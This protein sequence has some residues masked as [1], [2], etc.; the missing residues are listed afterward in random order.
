MP[1]PAYIMLGATAGQLRKY[2]L[3]TASPSHFARRPQNPYFVPI[4]LTPAEYDNQQVASIV[5]FPDLAGGFGKYFANT[6]EEANR[7]WLVKSAETRFPGTIC[8]PAL[9]T[10]TAVPT[11]PNNFNGCAPFIYSDISGTGE[12]Y[13]RAGDKIYTTS[14]TTWADEE[15]C[16]N[17]EFALRFRE[18]VIGTSRALFSLGMDGTTPANLS[19]TDG[20]TWNTRAADVV[21]LWQDPLTNTLMVTLSATGVVSTVGNIDLV[22]GATGVG[23]IGPM[24]RFIGQLEQVLYAIDR[25]GTLWAIDL[26]QASGEIVRRL[27]EA[28][29]GVVDGCLYQ[30]GQ[31]AL[32][33]GKRVILWHPARASRDVTPGA[34]DGVPAAMAY[35]IRS[36]VSINERLLAVVDYASTMGLWELR[37]SAWHVVT[38]KPTQPWHGA[39][40]GVTRRLMGGSGI[41][42]DP[43]NN[44]IWLASEASSTVK[45]WYNTLPPGGENVM[46]QE[47]ITAGDGFEATGEFETP[48]HHFGLRGLSGPLLRLRSIGENLSVARTAVYKYRV[49]GDEASAWTSIGTAT[50][51][52]QEFTFGSVGEGAEFS[53]VRF[54]VELARGASAT[55][56]DGSFVVEFIKIP[57]LQRSDALIIDIEATAT[58]QRRSAMAV[59]AALETLAEQKT[60]VAYRVDGEQSVSYRKLDGPRYTGFLMDGQ[61]QGSLQVNANELT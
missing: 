7:G 27:P 14:T 47:L 29:Y 39:T 35:T 42:Y 58:A 57:P 30:S 44:R 23:N 49:N 53:E 16:T 12:L 6:R 4:R 60:L 41:G 13:L 28:L 31:L 51:A 32:T 40:S 18:A 11:Q 45:T 48:W 50:A 56:P 59:L 46:V 1:G 19:S 55:S 10:E 9:Y 43:E 5:A 24:P 21:D 22:T 26:S 37:G 52:G 34:P 8:L 3:A 25:T 61:L 20:S 17:T 38:S 54:R 33:D 2:V 36:L 15:D